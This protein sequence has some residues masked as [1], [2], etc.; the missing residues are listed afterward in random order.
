MKK[1]DFLIL[2]LIFASL[3]CSAILDPKYSQIREDVKAGQDDFAFLK[4]KEYAEENPKSPRLREIEFAIGEYYFQ[5]HDYRNA[6]VQL[7]DYISKYPDAQNTIFAQAMVYRAL[8]KYTDEPALTQRLKEKLF[9]KPVF[10]I[11]TASKNKTYKSILG[12]TYETVDYVDK[13]E[14]FKNGE[15]I[16]AIKP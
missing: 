5:V 1:N 2:L 15:P 3:S 10:L 7:S 14:V 12:N 8:D 13:I 4:L 16:I 11:F 9:A 6:I